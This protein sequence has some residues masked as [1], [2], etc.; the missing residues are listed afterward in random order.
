LTVR[1]AE[2]D[3]LFLTPGINFGRFQVSKRAKLIF[4]V[5]YQFAVLPSKLTLEPLTPMYNHA[6]L[7][8]TRVAF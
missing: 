4:G 8:T 7:L 6:V 5:G 1:G 3:Q 2:R